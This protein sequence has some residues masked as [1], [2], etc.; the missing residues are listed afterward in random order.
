M[1]SRALAAAV[2][3]NERDLRCDFGRIINS[4]A[5]AMPEIEINA[6]TFGPYGVG[7][8]DGKSVMVAQAV[9]GDLLEV[10]LTSVRRDYAIARIDRIIR[11]GTD[12]RVPPCRYL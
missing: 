7:R 1:G 5:L 11:P 12:R 3:Y 2:G 8:I 6:M 10:A 9:P 4:S